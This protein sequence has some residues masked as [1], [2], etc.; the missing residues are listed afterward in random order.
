MGLGY[1][2]GV[3]R[4]IASILSGSFLAPGC[5]G[6][7]DPGAR[8]GNSLTQ[9]AVVFGRMNAM[10]EISENVADKYAAALNISEYQAPQ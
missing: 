10:L 3:K 6:G 2:T 4:A 9:G 5:W 1:T 7:P 8:T